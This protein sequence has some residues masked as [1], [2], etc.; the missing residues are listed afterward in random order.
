MSTCSSITGALFCDFGNGLG[1]QYIPVQDTDIVSCANALSSMLNVSVSGGGSID[2]SNGTCSLGGGV[3]GSACALSGGPGS[4]PAVPTTALF[5]G[6]G[7][8]A[9]GVVRRRRKRE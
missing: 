8:V 5:A 6:L 3:T 2:C 4:S 9:L 7:L 1:P